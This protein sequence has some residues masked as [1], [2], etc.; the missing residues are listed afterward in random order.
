MDIYANSLRLINATASTYSGILTAL[1]SALGSN[2]GSNFLFSMSGGN[3]TLGAATNFA[4]VTSVGTTIDQSIAGNGTV[5][6]QSSGNLTLA[7]STSVSASGTGTPLTL[8]SGGVFTNNAGASA[9]STIGGGRWLVYSQNPANDTLGSLSYGFKQYNATYGSTPVAQSTGNG[10]LYTLAPSLTASLTGATGK[11]Y[12]GTTTA[13]LTP[14]NLTSSGSLAGDTVALSTT[15]ATYANKNAGVGK[16]VTATGISSTA[17]DDSG[18]TVYGYQL[19]STSATGSIGT[20]SAAPLT[21]TANTATRSYGSANPAFSGTITGFVNGETLGSATSGTLAF[22]SP[23]ATG[24]NVGSYAVNGSGLTANNSN[25]TFLQNAGNA[26]AL[27]VNPA[28]LAY[29]ADT[30]SRMYGAANPTLTGTVAGF[31]NGD[32]QASA[33]SGSLTFTSPATATSNV[34]SYGITGSGLTA[35][36][37]YSLGQAAGNATALTINPALLTY[38]AD[39]ASRTYGAANPGFLGNSHR[40]R[41]WRDASFGHFRNSC[42]YQSGWHGQQR[43]LLCHQR[44]RSQCEQRQLHVP[45]GHREC[46]RAHRESR[47]LGLRRGCGLAYVRQRKSCLFWNGHGFRERGYAGFRYFGNIELHQPGHA[48]QQRR[49]LWRRWLRPHC[50]RQLHFGSSGRQRHGIDNQSG[51]C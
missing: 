26:T 43:R 5:L 8:A 46:H 22:S 36:S 15:G 7:A 27:T 25:Y 13:T 42:V 14:A 21:Y 29:T 33:T 48:D 11:T 37:N 45:A 40:F 28:A 19:T 2:A 51:A 47:S 24:S 32:T 50:R 18:A 1:S 31:V 4:L 35:N 38:T 30:V 44:F 39:T 6:L 10:V 23:A 49:V 34:G 20:I 3:L 17:T 41:E 12:D 16:T 9:L